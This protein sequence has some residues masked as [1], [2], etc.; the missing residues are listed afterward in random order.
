M[1]I[2]RVL[3]DNLC[4]TCENISFTNYQSKLAQV[5]V[6]VFNN[7]NKRFRL[8]ICGK[9]IRVKMLKKMDTGKQKMLI[10]KML[11]TTGFFHVL[12]IDDVSYDVDKKYCKYLDYQFE[13]LDLIC[14]NL[15]EFI[16]KDKVK[17]F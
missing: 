15:L 4:L 8:T 10:P 5:D 2:L 17:E 1:E 6:G 16:L 9:K 12:F 7:T 11:P 3:M 14:Y 13:D